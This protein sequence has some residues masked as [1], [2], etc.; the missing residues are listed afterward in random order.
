MARKNEN[1]AERKPKIRKVAGKPKPKPKRK[2]TDKPGAKRPTTPA[3]EEEV[4]V[5]LSRLR[6]NPRRGGRGR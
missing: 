1:T 4:L 3:D 5:S 6:A 2:T